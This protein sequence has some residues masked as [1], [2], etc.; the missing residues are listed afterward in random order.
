MKHSGSS[1]VRSNWTDCCKGNASTEKA[2]SGYNNAS[3]TNPVC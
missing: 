3:L 2:Q 1:G